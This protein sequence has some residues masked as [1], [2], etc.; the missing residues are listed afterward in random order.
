MKRPA[1]Y[2]LA[3]KRNGTLYVGVTSDLPGRISVHKQDLVEGFTKRYGVHTLVHYE[4][5][6]TM[7]D[8]IAREKQLKKFSRARKMALIEAGNPNW[9]DLYEEIQK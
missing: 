4:L 7:P 2:I 1:V 9:V 6:D 5:F 8:A 3:S